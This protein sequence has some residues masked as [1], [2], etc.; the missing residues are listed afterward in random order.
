MPKY[1]IKVS[2]TPEGARGIAKEGGTSR[3]DYI[4]KLL[5]NSGGTLES[6]YF[7]FGEDGR[8][9]DLRYARQR[10][11]CVDRFDSQFQ[12]G[13]PSQDGSAV[14]T[15]GTGPGHSQDRGLP[16][17]GRVTGHRGGAAHVSGER[18]AGL[19]ACPKLIV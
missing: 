1:L 11:G 5:Q 13:R 6:F 14:D 4:D 16:P 15:G 17:S 10:H 8:V 3:R 9:R 18:D 19:R 2:Y 7:A 12:R